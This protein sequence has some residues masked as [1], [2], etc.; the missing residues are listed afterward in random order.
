MRE[1]LTDG[2]DRYRGPVM[3]P[4]GGR[5]I[6]VKP[7]LHISALT[8][9][10]SLTLTAAAQQPQQNPQQPVP[11]APTPQQATPPLTNAATG[12]IKPGGGAGTEQPAA[13]SSGS[14][15]IQ[16]PVPQQPTGPP[17]RSTLQPQD[18][19]APPVTMTPAEIGAAIRINVTYVEVPVTVKDSKGNEVPGLQWRDFKVYENNNYAPLKV[20]TTDSYPLSI[21]F[22]VDQSLPRDQMEQVNTSLGALQ[23]ALTPFDEIAVFTY[24]NGARNQ[25]GGFTGAQSA[26]VPYI[27]SMTKSAGAEQLN[28]V[29]DGPF[30]SC[31]IRENGNCID[32]NLQAGKSAGSGYF[33]NIPKEIH[34]LNDAIL[35][36]AKELSSRPQGRRRIIYVISD[37]KENGSKAPYKQVLQYLQTNHILVYG[38]LVGEAARW[39]EGRLSRIHLPFTMYDNILVKY[40]LNTG[41]TLDSANGVNHIE[42]TYSDL[43]REARTRYTLVY[44]SHEPL[45]DGKYRKIDVRV[46]RPNLDVTAP[47]G[48]YPAASDAATH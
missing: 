46:S 28:P 38:T 35:A 39:G 43:A 47:L 30:A 25:S 45:L 8:A 31:N 24:G 22:V 4:C 7:G 17:P 3:W 36:A 1:P 42:K 13:G 40:T 33:M 9:L 34:T 29:N 5:E 19:Q 26:R 15:D 27:L 11:D 21:A 12:P 18:N 44:A 2:E 6:P 10:L 37:G 48:Y 23:G 16:G 14:Q 32:P 20:F 41:G